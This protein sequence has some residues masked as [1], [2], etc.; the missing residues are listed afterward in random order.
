MN[1]TIAIDF[2]T[3]RTKLSYIDPTTGRPELMKLGRNEATWIPSVFYLGGDGHTRLF[4]EEASDFLENDPDGVLSDPPLKRQLRKRRVLAANGQGAAPVEFLAL[5]FAGLRKRASELRLFD[6]KLPDSLVLTKPSAAQYGPIIEAMLKDAAVNAGFKEVHLID[7]PVAAARAWLAANP[8]RDD[9]YI[10]VLD[11]GG[12][13]VDWACLHKTCDGAFEIYP[14]IPLGGCQLGGYDVD[15]EICTWLI[16]HGSEAIR[17]GMENSA[18]FV[19]K[20]VQKLK[21]MFSGSGIST[22]FRMSGADFAVPADVLDDI[23]RDG[24]TEQVRCEFG[25]VVSSVS[26]KLKLAEPTVLLVGG[27]A[28][29]RG[30]QQAVTEQCKCNAVWWE[31][32]EYATVLGA[33]H[34]NLKVDHEPGLESKRASKPREI[35][36]Y[37]PPKDTI[38]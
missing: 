7:E 22:G 21:E 32:S 12:G 9:D 20:R 18:P 37:K 15:E 23:I 27:S 25:K 16:E 31:R 17:A 26:N 10:I 3:A 34:G 5:L 30:F 29:L 1:Y 24:F 6:G 38:F 2:G 8:K 14:D 11:C 28:R 35:P 36:E 33:L 13:T 4:G 19:R